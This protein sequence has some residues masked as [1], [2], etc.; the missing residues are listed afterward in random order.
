MIIK[1]LTVAENIVSAAS[2]VNGSKL[3]SV[4]NTHT[5]PVIINVGD[6][7]VYIAAGER[8]VIEKY[9]DDTIQAPDAG[10]AVWATGVAY[11]G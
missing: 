3:V 2:D 10:S 5:A 4:V 7:T 11:K 1:P 9:T 8:V 6:N